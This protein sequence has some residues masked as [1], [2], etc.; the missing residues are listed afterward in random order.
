VNF[1][2]TVKL[3]LIF[4]RST[5]AKFGSHDCSH[6]RQIRK[7]VR[8]GIARERADSLLLQEKRT[9]PRLYLAGDPRSIRAGPGLRFTPLS[10]FHLPRAVRLPNPGGP[11][12]FQ[13]SNLRVRNLRIDKCSLT[14]NLVHRTYSDAKRR[15]TTLVTKSTVHG[16]HRHHHRPVT[17]SPDTFPN[18]GT[19]VRNPPPCSPL[20]SIVAEGSMVQRVSTVAFGGSRPARSTCR[21]R[22][23]P[24]N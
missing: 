19:S 2:A 17:E 7:P 23:R 8:K 14:E 3:N 10:V 6:L 1:S 4:G 15:V 13:A 11:R 21:C 20:P 9:G 12:S 18:R 24:P 16:G 5:G 22:S